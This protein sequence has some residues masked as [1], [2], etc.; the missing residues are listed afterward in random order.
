MTVDLETLLFALLALL[1]VAVAFP[2]LALCLL[3]GARHDHLVRRARRVY[4]LD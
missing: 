3:W 4:G 1:V 2:T